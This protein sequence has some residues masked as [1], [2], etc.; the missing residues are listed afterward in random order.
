VSRDARE[1]AQFFIRFEHLQA[2][3]AEVLRRLWIEQKRPLPRVNKTDAKTVDFL[4]Y[5][6]PDIIEQAVQVF[7]PY[8]E[9]W[10]YE[11][12][13]EW[14]TASVSVLSHLNYQMVNALRDFYWRWIK[15][16]PRFYGRLSKYRFIS[17]EG[18]RRGCTSVPSPTH[19]ITICGA[20]LRVVK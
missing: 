19:S 5:Y 11:L 10:G 13:P 16:S 14:G 9:E 20:V 6:T 12:P 7:G 2:D 1:Y 17:L 15:W 4:S 8:M 18:M 3:F